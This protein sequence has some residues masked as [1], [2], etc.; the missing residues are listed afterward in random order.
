[1]ER[2]RGSATLMILLLMVGV[3]ILV[4]TALKSTIALYELSLERMKYVQAQK[5]GDALT[6]YGIAAAYA[7]R[8]MPHETTHTFAAWPPPAGSYEGKVTVTPG[9]AQWRIAATLTQHTKTVYTA[10]CIVAGEKEEWRIV[11]WELGE[12]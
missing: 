11:R 2:S 4:L 8:E 6:L 9:A 12:R 1:M 5:A 7:Q 3:T 10:I